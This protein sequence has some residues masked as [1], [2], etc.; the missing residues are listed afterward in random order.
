MITG[1]DGHTYVTAPEVRDTYPD[2]TP[3][4]LHTWVAAGDLAVVTRGELA[5][6]LGVAHLPPDV[7]VNAPARA[8]GKSTPEYLYRWAD[9]VRVETSKRLT[10]RRRGGRPRSTSTKGAATRELATLTQ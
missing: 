6:A 8:R 7:D 9:V 5:A 4:L 2:V 10:R 3:A 1:H